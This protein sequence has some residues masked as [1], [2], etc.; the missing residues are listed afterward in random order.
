M[1]EKSIKNIR[2]EFKQH[3]IFYTP[4]ALAEKLNFRRGG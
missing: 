4:L 3:G 1:K 2:Q